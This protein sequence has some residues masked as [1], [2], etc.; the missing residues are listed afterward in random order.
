METEHKNCEQVIDSHMEDRNVYLENLNDIIGDNESSSED[1]ENA[2]RELSEFPAGIESF[3]V[4]KIILS[5][6]GPADWIE[7]K[8]N[9]EGD[10]MGMSYHWQD[11]GDH[12]QRKI[13]SDSYLWDFAMQIVDTEQ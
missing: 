8:V 12:A 10:V 7:V 3:K 11:W 4:I 2:L 13:Y 5:G 1:V 9:D 6:G